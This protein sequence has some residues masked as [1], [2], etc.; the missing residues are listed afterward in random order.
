MLHTIPKAFKNNFQHDSEHDVFFFFFLRTR[1]RTLECL[2]MF[3]AQKPHQVPLKRARHV[4][5][6]IAS[7]ICFPNGLRYQNGEKGTT[8]HFPRM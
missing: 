5:V 6:V 2:L 3:A 4:R 7:L 8:A 1:L